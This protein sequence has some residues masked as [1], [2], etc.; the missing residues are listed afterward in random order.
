MH[1][2]MVLDHF[3]ADSPAGRTGPAFCVLLG[4]DYAGKSSAMRHLR[5]TSAPWRL[6]SADDA[7][8]GPEH[9]LI[10]RLR[11]AVVTDV[12]ARPDAWSPEFFATL[13][14]TAVLHLRDRLLDDRTGTPAVVDSYYYKLLAKCRLAGVPE[15]PMFAWW[16]T[17]PRPR[18]VIWLDVPPGTAWGRTRG[19][20]ALNRLEYYGD[21]PDR[22]GFERYQSDLAK[23]MRDEIRHLPVT[24]VRAD[25]DP[26][27]TARDIQEALA[28]ELA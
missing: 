6:V 17:L 13:I 18:R 1:C 20:A 16:R 23:T 8:L 15:N 25:G 3:T 10:R 14:Q 27:R 4:A 26:E 5:D 12:A 11:R 2:S 22:D 24:V 7:F 21:H 19:G 28:H 9:D